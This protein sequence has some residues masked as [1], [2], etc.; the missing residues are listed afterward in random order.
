MHPP[1]SEK[2]SINF[3]CDTDIRR[4]IPG[5]LREEGENRAN[6]LEGKKE[7]KKALSSPRNRGGARNTVLYP[8]VIHRPFLGIVGYMF[9]AAWNRPRGLFHILTLRGASRARQFTLG[10]VLRGLASVRIRFSMGYCIFFTR[11]LVLCERVSSF[12]LRST[13]L[14]VK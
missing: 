11:N 12:C 3:H 8:I 1:V 5:K 6:R 9:P 10:A 13:L 2:D 7:L 4:A 14:Q